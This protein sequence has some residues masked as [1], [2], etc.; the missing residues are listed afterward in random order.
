MNTIKLEDLS[1]LFEGV[2]EIFDEKKDEL[3]EMDANMGD[4]DLGLTMQKGFSQLPRLIVENEEANDIGK[5]LFK[6]ASKMAGIVP[7]TMGTLMSSGIMEAGKVLKGKEE[8]DTADFAEFLMAFAQ[9]VQKRGKCQ[10][11]D[12]TIL[13]S[14]L[15][16]AERA[17]G[18][19]LATASFKDVIEAA[20]EGAKD[21][22]EATKDMIPKYGKAAVFSAKAKGIPDQGAV[23]GMY[24]I[25]GLSRFLKDR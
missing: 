18:L 12:R 14:V 24:L 21:G 5:T 7:S 15:S 9:G 20:C 2:A 22:V 6:S 1:K 17:K 13:D 3:C 19:D 25:E 11:G 4:G 8:L 16:A 10:A 23:A